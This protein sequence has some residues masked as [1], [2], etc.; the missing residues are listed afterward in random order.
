M[1]DR[2]RIW[3]IILFVAVFLVLAGASA[4][5][6]FYTDVLW[7]ADLGHVNVVWVTLASQ[8]AVGLLFGAVFFAVLYA[9]MIIARRMAPRAFLTVG[10]SA[11]EQLQQGLMQLKTA[12]EPIIG[13]LLVG[14][15]LV[16]ALG[17][18]AAMASQWR[19]FQLA[20]HTVPF[21]VADAQ[22]GRDASFFVF[23]LPAL[24]SVTDWVISTL[25]TVLVL[26]AVVHLFD[27]AI[28]PW[29]RLRGFAPHVKAHLS[30]LAGLIVATKA[31]DYWLQTFELDFSP[32]G[33][34]L[35]ASYT[36]V[37]A[38]LP[39]LYILVV[40]ALISG[41]ILLLNIRSKG[42][43]LPVIALGVWVAASVLVGSVY[44]ALVQ[45]FRVAPN[46]VALEAPYIK[47]NIVATRL[48][49]GL[50]DVV[51]R[52]FAANAD[53]TPADVASDSLTV[54]NIRLWDP[55]VMKTTYKQLQ[56]IRTYYDFND[57]DVDRYT[58]DGRRTEVLISAR[59]MNID[60]LS[61]QAKTWVNEHLFYTHGYGVVVSPVNDVGSDG[62][63]MFT[64]KDIPPTTSTDLTV[65]RPA[66]YYGEETNNY[67]I[68]GSALPEFDYPK[69][70][71]KAT[72]SYIGTTGVPI[73]GLLTRL[74]FAIRF[75]S[76]DLLLSS[77]V[78]PQSKVLFDRTI[79]TR[80]NKLAPFLSLDGDPYP[81]IIGGHVVWILDGYTSTDHYPY[82]QRSA[83]GA[84]YVRNSV[85]ITVDA[86]D[87]SVHLYAFD[88]GD[89]IL[90]A[91]RRVFPGL[92]ED[93]SAMP[94]GVRE[95]LRYPEDLFKLQAE[96][97]RNYH[98]TDPQV[99]YNKEDSWA[100]PTD[101][102]GSEMS[103]FYVLMRLP[104]ENSE[105]FLMMAPFT[106]R[107]K[108]NMIGWM[109]AKSDP[110][111]YGQ[112][113]VYS[114]P[115]QKLILGPEQVRAR[116][117]QEPSISQQLTLWNQSGSS[118]LFGNLLVLP[119]KDSI[120]YVEP[121]YLQAE[122]TAIPQLTR[123]IVAYGNN[124]A[125]QPD[126]ASALAQVFGFSTQVQ[127]TAGVPATQPTTGTPTPAGTVA[128]QLASAR[129]LYDRA[130]AAQRAGDWATYGKLIN[131]LGTALRKLA[132]QPS[133]GPAAAKP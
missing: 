79:T 14:I 89:P 53:L 56:E 52:P 36:D 86:Y 92:V 117:N 104:A 21:G 51:G 5:A 127:P 48:A 29:E 109:A 33:Q 25:V 12:L 99:F 91:W 122:Q 40:I 129:D 43:R 6:T 47:R 69:G 54:D 87:G 3:V 113:L 125:M 9:N 106:P 19:L 121:L 128:Q 63:P 35:G 2:R 24:R 27:G 74:A 82:S 105:D 85:K 28:R 10:G 18:G 39:A 15:S 133:S 37:H 107:G 77:Y 46:E 120:L 32:R 50:T 55:S 131:Q 73:G 44:P 64:L 31:L 111:N 66:I 103:P 20:L 8:W 80:V 94:A 84:N 90:A 108:S 124:V 60:Q 71:D 13:W 67:V 100:L 49:F 75:G 78:T 23:T 61:D 83:N 65:T 81:A 17:S 72:T 130:V 88:P 59:E 11:P 4:V 123:V 41:A 57:V 1:P 114:F 68:A 38:Q 110:A 34:V 101:A 102:N 70:A 62:V 45:A 30:V 22:F 26:T 76:S 98:M 7:F 132:S 16:L 95:H 115:K 42:W 116:I 96:V 119:I 126:L 93:A 58:I 118:V 112:R 97:Y